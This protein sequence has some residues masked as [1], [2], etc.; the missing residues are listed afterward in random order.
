V[1]DWP[2]LSDGA[3]LSDVGV[4]L[5]S[6][7]YTRVNCGASNT[8][9]NWVQLIAST[10]R[11]A[12]GFWLIVGASS[13]GSDDLIDIGIG[14][15]GSEVVVISNLLFSF[16]RTSYCIFV[17]LMLPAGVRV[18]A[19]AQTYTSGNYPSVGLILN[20]PGFLPSSV[21]SRC[22][23]YGANEADSGG[24]SVDPGITA[25]TKGAWTEIVA[26]TT[27]PIKML[28]AINGCAS[29][30]HTYNYQFLFDI[31]MGAAGS[32]IV[33]VPNLYFYVDADPF[34]FIPMTFGPFM[35]NIPAGSRLAIRM[36]STG[37]ADGVRLADF[38]LYGVD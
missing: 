36:Q 26:A 1:G 21:L 17:P 35:V 37:I 9:G 5:A 6:S 30:N 20:T 38:V 24:V 19:R 33:V 29:T 31:G 34:K 23:T 22:T 28:S 25:H 16:Q 15:A 3:I 18:A 13:G 7:Y 2:I 27:N 12:N 11:Q 32:E 14:P 8:K 4:V 10:P